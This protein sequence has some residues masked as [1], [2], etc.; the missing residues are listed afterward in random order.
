MASDEMATK[1]AT[2]K[3]RASR[4][5]Q[6]ARK[7]QRKAFRNAQKSNEQ[8]ETSTSDDYYATPVP[9]ME[10]MNESH[11]KSLGRWFPKAVV[12][13]SSVHYTNVDVRKM[14]GNKPSASILL[15]YQYV[16]DPLW[17]EKQVDHLIAYLIRISEVRPNLG[18]RL[19]VAPEGLNVTL[20]AV[21]CETS[22]AASTLRHFCKDLQSFDSKAFEKTDFK[23]VDGLQADRHFKDLKIFPVQELVFYGFPKE[24]KDDP[25]PLDNTGVHL[26]PKNFHKM[27]EEDG[28]VVIDVRNH[29]EAALGRFDGQQRHDKE[30]EDIHPGAEYLDPKMR[31]STD[32]AKW[33]LKDETKDKIK[34]KKVLMFCTGGVRCERASSYLKSTLPENHASGVFQL[35]GGIENYLKEF[36]TGGHWRGKNFVF[37]KREACSAGDVDGDG[38]VI[39][40]ESVTTDTKCCLCSRP[41]DRYVGKKKCAMCGVP[42]LMCDSC[43]SNKKKQQELSARCP[44][45]VEEDVTLPASEV[46]WTNNGVD[47][48]GSEGSIKSKKS[49]A[50]VLKWGGGHSSAGKKRDR[51]KFSKIPCRFGSDCVRKDCFFAHPTQPSEAS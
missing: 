36:P 41:W 9:T 39:K 46:E 47:V 48:V 40:N 11:A 22:T 19:R 38:G 18:G 25:A 13:K 26:D 37:D 24:G 28:T 4:K 8:Q 50:S 27:L 45:C 51:K 5:E 1:I 17:T 42:V 14:T 21:D 23:F 20:S 16:V 10:E 12:R 6:K 43:L 49:A 33:L 7:Q 29:Y 32:F 44:L 2:T 15:F 31:K 34:G 35:Q 3:R 30:A